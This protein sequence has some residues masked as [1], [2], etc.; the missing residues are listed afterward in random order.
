MSSSNTFPWDRIRNLPLENNPD[1][2]NQLEDFFPAL[3]TGAFDESSEKS[4]LL[5]L[6]RVLQLSA[7][8]K[9]D[10]LEEAENELAQSEK[11]V[12]DLKLKSKSNQVFSPS[13]LNQSQMEEMYRN[14]LVALEE[15][16]KVCF[17]IN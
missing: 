15:E 14:E 4:D 7:L 8:L 3:T 16:L 9:N 12:N 6:C 11:E 17:T 2:D 5:K 13:N 10:F 1:L